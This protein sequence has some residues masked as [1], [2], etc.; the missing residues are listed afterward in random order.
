MR[1][2][3]PPSLNY[4]REEDGERGY[5]ALARRK[6]C[7]TVIERFSSVVLHSFLSVGF[8]EAGAAPFLFLFSVF[9]STCVFCIAGPLS[10]VCFFV[11][12]FVSV[13]LSLSFLTYSSVQDPRGPA[14]LHAVAKQRNNGRSTEQH[15]PLEN[16]WKESY[17]ERQRRSVRLRSNSTSSSP[18]RDTPSSPSP[19]LL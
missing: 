5:R 4:K 1:C 16:L 2:K 14:L 6:C 10:C 19:T 15:Q 9:C 18:T 11:H 3:R 8:R 13:S 17:G 12:T 7:R